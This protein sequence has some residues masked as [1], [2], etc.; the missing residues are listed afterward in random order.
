[1]RMFRA[2]TSCTR[3][4]LWHVACRLAL[5]RITRSA[6]E[7]E[8]TVTMHWIRAGIVGLVVALAVSTTAWGDS[9]SR[10]RRAG[11]QLD[12]F[13]ENPSIT[14]TGRG[15]LTLRLDHETETIEYE[16][17]Y[18]RLEGTATVSHIHTSR[19]RVN[20]PISVFL[21]GGAKEACPAQ[22]GTVKGVI[23]AAEIAAGSATAQG[24]NTFDEF[25]SALRASALYVNVHS[26]MW[27]GGEIR[28]QIFET[29][30]RDD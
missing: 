28:G 22:E 4:P 23:V 9:N 21:C 14:T 30:R 3:R 29:F 25:V 16:L 10:P 27:G 13:Q 19:S 18:S 20:G 12:G 11:S 26:S 8:V 1:M 2:I 5:D 15:T 6:S 24:L 17:R 7:K